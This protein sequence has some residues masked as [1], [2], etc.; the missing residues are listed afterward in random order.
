MNRP[1]VTNEARIENP[2]VESAC[3][4]GASLA[5]TPAIVIRTK[6]MSFVFR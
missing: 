1:V 5:H 2:G 4:D 6:D 3:S